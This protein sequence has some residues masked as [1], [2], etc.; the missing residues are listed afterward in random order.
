MGFL[1]EA[2]TMANVL[3]WDPS[4]DVSEV[5][6]LLQEAVSAHSCYSVTSWTATRTIRWT[7]QYGSKALMVHLI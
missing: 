2:G 3:N 4:Q 1:G 7:S 5:V 6:Q